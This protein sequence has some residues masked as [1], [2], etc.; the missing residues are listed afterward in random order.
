MGKILWTEAG[1]A[2]LVNE[3]EFV[4]SELKRRKVAGMSRSYTRSTSPSRLHDR[5]TEQQDAA[6]T[7]DRRSRLEALYAA[8]QPQRMVPLSGKAAFGQM[9]TVVIESAGSEEQHERTFV[10]GGVDESIVHLPY[11]VISCTS[12]LGRAVLG[13]PV[14][15]EVEYQVNGLDRF[16]RITA[17][18]APP[19]VDPNTFR[20]AA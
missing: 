17:I 18:D 11:E 8:V 3:I 5:I 20:K 16:A 14:G 6:V 12:P 4:K 2:W 10:L 9:L 15:E 1:Y 7:D 13:K 19:V